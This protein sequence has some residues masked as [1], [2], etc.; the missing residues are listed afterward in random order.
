MY[1]VSQ[2]VDTLQLQY[3]G[4]NQ[5]SAQNGIVTMA[6]EISNSFQELTSHA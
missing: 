5:K 1:A 3:A 4:N 6:C 2:L